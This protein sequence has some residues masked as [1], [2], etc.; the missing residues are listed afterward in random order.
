[1]EIAEITRDMEKVKAAL[2]RVNADYNQALSE[3]T[4]QGITSVVEVTDSHGKRISKVA[5]R[6]ACKTLATARK[7]QDQLGSHLGSLRNQL[8]LKQEQIER[9]MRRGK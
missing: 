9:Q 6:Q 1:M 5:I 8:R 3:I 2:D 7:L 4:Q